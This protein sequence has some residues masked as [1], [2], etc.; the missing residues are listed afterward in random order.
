M[1][2]NAYWLA[3]A[4]T[5]SLSGA[6]HAGGAETAGSRPASGKKPGGQVQA[7][8][9]RTAE[10]CQKQEC[11]LDV[12]VSKC[13][14]EVKPYVIVMTGKAPVKMVWR[15]KGGEFAKDPIRFKEAE[16]RRIFTRASASGQEVVFN[17]NKKNGIWHYGIRVTEGGQECPE[18]DPTGVNDMGSQGDP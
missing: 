12:T 4:L 18:L 3:A 16:A 17:N 14:V 13:V 11:V 6:A 10:L 1:T 2:R 15:I 5:L 9:T 7:H 8:A